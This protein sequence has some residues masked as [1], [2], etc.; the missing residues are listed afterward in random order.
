MYFKIYV[1]LKFSKNILKL[2]VISQPYN[3]WLT[4]SMEIPEVYYKIYGISDKVELFDVFEENGGM[5]NSLK[6]LNEIRTKK[7]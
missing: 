1:Q 3:N 6:K 2:Y 5:D 7:I 4:Y